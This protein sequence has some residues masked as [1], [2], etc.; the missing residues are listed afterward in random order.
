MSD[1]KTAK[2]DLGIFAETVLVDFLD[3]LLSHLLLLRTFL[4]LLLLLLVHVLGSLPLE[5]LPRV[6]LLLLLLAL[7]LVSALLL[8][9]R[10]LLLLLFLLVRAGGAAVLRA[11]VVARGRFIP[12]AT[13]G[14]RKRGEAVGEFGGGRTL[15]GPRTRQVSQLPT[16]PHEGSV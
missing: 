7:L 14:R 1:L 2:L 13:G 11:R 10:R 15:T 6:L 8:L 12:A 9:L 5:L 16:Q 4:L 3:S